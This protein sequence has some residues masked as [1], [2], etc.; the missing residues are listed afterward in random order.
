MTA[1]LLT[2]CLLFSVKMEREYTWIQ[3]GPG[4]I[5]ALSGSD[6]VWSVTLTRS[7]RIGEQE[8]PEHPVA[9]ASIEVHDGKPFVKAQDGW[10][11]VLDPATGARLEDRSPAHKGFFLFVLVGGL[12][13]LG[14]LLWRSRRRRS[15]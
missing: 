11:Y 8:G 14:L 3:T 4:R 15:A 1:L 2:L 9:I 5:T 10:T 13:A 7:D 6:T 12:G